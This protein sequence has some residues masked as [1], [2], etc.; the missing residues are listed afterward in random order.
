MST[1]FSLKGKDFKGQCPRT[2]FPTTSVRM[3]NRTKSSQF[4]QGIP[5][6]DCVAERDI[7]VPLLLHSAVLI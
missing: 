4:A 3:L 6:R 7:F 1:N 2:S 5:T